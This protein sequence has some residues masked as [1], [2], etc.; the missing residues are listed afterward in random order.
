M[1][2]GKGAAEE[3]PW[4][5]PRSGE[6]VG[7][8]AHKNWASTWYEC[9]HCDYRERAMSD[10]LLV[11]DYCPH[12]GELLRRVAAAQGDEDGTAAASERG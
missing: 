7:P 3:D 2:E 5:R 11:H 8:L 6:I 4:N 9:P 12:H 10:G 1:A